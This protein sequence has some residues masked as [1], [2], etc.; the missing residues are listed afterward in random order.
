[1][2]AKLGRGG[3]EYMILGIWNGYI[4]NFWE[5]QNTKGYILVTPWANLFKV[6]GGSIGSENDGESIHW[7]SHPPNIKHLHSPIVSHIGGKGL[8]ARKCTGNGKEGWLSIE[9]YD[10]LWVIPCIPY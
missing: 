1:M 7:E 5:E 10:E 2:G 9:N 6:L 3:R 4:P 8:V